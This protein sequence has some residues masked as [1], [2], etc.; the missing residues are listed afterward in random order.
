IDSAL[1][2][3]IPDPVL[4]GF[5]LQNLAREGDGWRWKVN[6][7]AIKQH[8]P[9]LIDFPVPENGWKIDIPTLFMRGENSDYIGDAELTEIE[10]HFSDARI[11]TLK[12]AGHWL[13]A[14]QPEQFFDYV[15]SFSR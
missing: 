3:A 5:L 14:E 13:H 6:W 9:D 2:P 12:L 8:M 11:E 4:R 7:A 1:A 10:R 15:V